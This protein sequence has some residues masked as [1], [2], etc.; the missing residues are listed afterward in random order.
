[1][2][3]YNEELRE[4]A[5]L[6]GLKKQRNPDGSKLKIT[7]FTVFEKVRECIAELTELKK[8]AASGPKPVKLLIKVNAIA[9]SPAAAQNTTTDPPN[10]KRKLEVPTT[11]CK[12]HKV[13]DT[14]ALNK[15]KFDLVDR[16]PEFPASLNFGKWQIFK[17]VDGEE[18]VTVGFNKSKAAFSTKCVLASV[19]LD[20]LSD[21]STL[22]S[23]FKFYRSEWVA[24]KIGDISDLQAARTQERFWSEYGGDSRVIEFFSNDYGGWIP[25]RVVDYIPCKRKFP[26]LLQCVNKPPAG[27]TKRFRACRN[28]SCF[29]DLKCE[30]K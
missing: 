5:T 17:G 1:M 25:V 3:L 11:E 28:F 18:L 2:A 16:E 27:K 23:A 24:S 22:K 6:L 4:I 12:R 29:R 9:S 10:N 14:D 8:I 20:P 26:I 13:I 21:V 30:S 7:P 15:D 19:L